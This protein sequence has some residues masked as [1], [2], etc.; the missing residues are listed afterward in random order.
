MCDT[1]DVV[2]EQI[3]YLGKDSGRYVVAFQDRQFQI[4]LVPLSDDDRCTDAQFWVDINELPID[5]NDALGLR[6]TIDRV[7][8]RCDGRAAALATSIRVIRRLIA[9]HLFLS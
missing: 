4:S 2:S 8:M 1:V 5:A 7:R 6:L 9:P 3:D